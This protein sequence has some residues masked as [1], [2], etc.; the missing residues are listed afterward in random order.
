MNSF[1][2][3]TFYRSL[4]RHKLYAALN[5][6]GLAVGIA[7]F[8]VLGLYVRFETSYERWLPHADEIYI[9]ETQSADDPN[10]HAQQG[11]P[12]AAWSAISR[13]LP[14]TVGTR[15]DTPNATVIKDGIGVSEDLARVDP[16]FFTVFG[17]SAVQG[18]LRTALASPSSIV[19][20]QK[21][22]A[23]YFAAANPIGST[24]TITFNGVQHLYRV[25]AVVADLPSNTELDFGLIV[26][27]TITSDP[28]SPAYKGDHQWNYSSP[29]TFVRLPDAAAARRF[30]AQLAQVV[31]RH[32]QSETTDEPD[33]KIDLKLQRFTHTHFE[34]PGSELT[35]TT[36]GIVGLL[37]L[38]IAVVNYVN[39][40]TARAGMRAREVAMRKVLG[41]DRATLARHYIG[42]AVATTMIAGV[43]G[44]ALA[45][46]GLPLVN[47]ASGLTLEITY[48]GRNGVLLPLVALALVVGLLAGIYPAMVLSR[49]P[50]AAVLA[51]ARSP[52]GGRV[53]TRIRE[54]LVVLQ[55]TIAI[56]FV[57]GTLVLVA[58]TRHVRAAD[59]GYD[60][61]NILLVRSLA[62]DSLDAT[63]R[64][65]LLHRFAAAPGVAAITVGNTVPGGGVFI[66]SNN[67]KVPG[68][69]GDGPAIQFFQTTPGYFNVLGARLIAGR[70]FDLAHPGDAN[71]NL[72]SG[73]HSP[74]GPIPNNVV[75]NR[76]AAVALHFA[77][78]QAA[79]GKT[80]GGDSPKTVIGVVEDMRFGSARSPVPPTLY[81]F[82]LRDP[83]SGFAI[84]R[85]TGDS[86]ATT[87]TVRRIWRE[88]VPQ[89]PFDSR[90]A[91]QALDR[92]YA[93]D[94]HAARLFTIGAVLAV[95]I[96]CV[97]LWGLASFNT[98]R[99]V[100]EIGIRKT[101]GASSAD[102]VK[103]LVGQF[104]RPVLIANLFAW[105]L[106]W[107]AMRTWLAGFNDRIALSPLFFV[108]ATT[109]ALAIAVL[110]V[111]A[112]SLRAARSAPAWAL[113][114]D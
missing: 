96:G 2:L 84:L 13:D 98:A 45:E 31:A 34:T 20:T 82:Q 90:T 106:A 16:Q 26:P 61:Q 58:Q 36:L 24:M 111:F 14:S 23:K 72:T 25:T 100:K 93:R 52:G 62:N 9:I 53:G 43:I 21:T 59:P 69:S 91:V 85:F 63:Q 30:D 73:D 55:F 6:G 101:L 70:L 99:R 51:S 67:F 7:V 105:P 50:A 86:Q 57:V 102:I 28:T 12:I 68:L 76:S 38:L 8:L 47:A 29:R 33:Y 66:S 107:F 75:L 42:D 35:V 74:N 32:A 95:V 46:C 94:D 17:L 39:L 37:T 89:V 64:A 41:A 92:F 108:A 56:A 11:T 83:Q 40:A 97:G 48:L 87:D 54:A 10:Y 103:L 113:R 71:A 27:M 79:I 77:S 80:F 5:I 78:P 22:A 4:T 88:V 18:D 109:L 19:I 3:L 65:T 1:T 112:Q 49:F 104:L 44:L 15:I 60:R 110:T 114:H 81:D